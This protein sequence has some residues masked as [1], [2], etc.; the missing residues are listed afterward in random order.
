MSPTSSLAFALAALTSAAAAAQ[1]P[2]KAAA[3]SG[4]PDPIRLRLAHVYDE[5]HP[6]HKAFE[7]F[8]EVLQAKS[9][10]TLDAQIFPSGKLGDEKAC[11][12]YLRQGVLDVTTVSGNGL[13]G[14]VPEATFLDLLYLWRDRDHWQRGLDGP[15]GTRLTELIRK[16]TSKGGAPPFEVLGYWG[17]SEVN[18]LGRK[19][20]YETMADLAG[21]RLRIQDS[22]LQVELWKVLGANPIILPFDGIRAGIEEGT[23]EAVPVTNVTNLSRKFYEVT[24]HLTQMGMSI[25]ARFF[26]MSGHTWAK[27][28]ADQRAAV[29]AAA[30][31]ATAI[32]RTIEAE[33]NDSAIAT[34]ERDFGVKVHP[35]KDR[36]AIREKL[37]PVQ[38]RYAE[39]LGLLDLLHTVDEEW[40]KASPG[41]K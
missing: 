22:P 13:E 29:L 2:A 8:R 33:Q 11:V 36:Y 32:A 35:F 14:V 23:V 24:P 26:L 18:M 28:G 9:N 34:L 31:E 1:P 5:N 12:S 37:R 10:G 20:G 7:R 17:G 15:V 41:K 40:G 27:L 21:V 4:A 19:R 25:V 39:K 38:E 6:W 30:R 16:G 3:K